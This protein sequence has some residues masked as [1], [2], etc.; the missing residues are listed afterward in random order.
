M[1]VFC[2]A[3]FDGGSGATAAL[4][5]WRDIFLFHLKIN[6]GEEGLLWA[7]GPASGRSVAIVIIVGFCLTTVVG[8]TDG[9]FDG[10]DWKGLRLGVVFWGTAFNLGQVRLPSAFETALLEALHRSLGKVVD[11]DAD[12]L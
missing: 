8:G 12:A 10:G 11:V 6:R 3:R 9:G 7:A 4:V 1:G 2:V 5:H